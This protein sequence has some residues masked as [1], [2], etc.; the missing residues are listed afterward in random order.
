M[1]GPAPPPPRAV[2]RVR[3]GRAFRVAAV[4]AADFVTPRMRRVVFQSD[5][6]SG[7]RSEAYDDHI[8]LF[9]PR[10]DRRSVPRAARGS[11]GLV[12]PD[13]AVRP[14]ARDYTPR[15]FD[16]ARNRLTVDFVLHGEG[17]GSTFGERAAAGDVIGIAGPVSSM[18]V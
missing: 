2:E 5:E 4:V 8:R 7:F 10:A 13:G 15:A 16:P 11:N 17:P 6:L 14:D 18:V 12:F 1:A 9:I 3:H